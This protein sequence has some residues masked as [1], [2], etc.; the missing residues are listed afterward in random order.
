MWMSRKAVAAALRL[1]TRRSASLRP[2]FLLEIDPVAAYPGAAGSGHA[3]SITREIG[4]AS[5]VMAGLSKR[6]FGSVFK[7]A[8]AADEPVRDAATEFACIPEPNSGGRPAARADLKQTG[9]VPQ[10]DVPANRSPDGEAAERAHSESESVD[11]RD[12]GT[13]DTYLKESTRDDQFSTQLPIAQSEG[14]ELPASVEGL[15]RYTVVREHARG[16]LGMV[17]VAHDDTLDRQV[18]LKQIISKRADDP[19]SRDRFIREAKTTGQLEHPGI[20]PIYDL[21]I[22]ASGRPFYAMRFIE[23]RTFADAIQQF[24]GQGESF[25]TLE[26][27]QL[28]GRFVD[29]C[30]AVGYAHSHCV[31]HR[32]LKPE[33]VMLGQ[34]GE[35][36]VLDWGLAKRL[37]ADSGDDR[38]VKP[39][40]TD[41]V[42]DS[43]PGGSD[44]DFVTRLGISM[45]TP[46]Y[47]SPEQALGDVRQLGPPSDVYSLGATLYAL[48]TGRPPIVAD[49]L[50]SAMWRTSRGD[51]SPPRH[52]AAR[53]PKPLDAICT[54]AL[55]T[56]PGKRYQTA[57][58]LGEDVERWLA[59]SAVSAYRE[60]LLERLARF[61]RRHRTW[62][63]AGAAALLLTTI[64]ATLAAVL[65][66]RANLITNLNYGVDTSLQESSGLNELLG[67]SQTE[68]VRQ[69]LTLAP[70]SARANLDKIRDRFND[71]LG[72]A[73]Q[74]PRVDDATANQL[75]QQ[76]DRFER[77]AL[78]L[79]ASVATDDWAKVA[80]D[81]RD[82]VAAR[83]QRENIIVDFNADDLTAAGADHVATEAIIR[84]IGVQ[85]AKLELSP[86]GGVLQGQH[87]IEQWDRPV[88]LN[89]RQVVGN[90][91]VEATFADWERS[92][93]VGVAL[94]TDEGLAYEFLITTTDFDPE[95]VRPARLAMLRPLGGVPINDAVA[96]ILRGNEV[97]RRFAA[98]LAPG[99]M[100]IRA[101]RT[102]T[103]ELQI[104]INGRDTAS[105]VDSYPLPDELKGG[106]AL[107]WPTSSRLLG[108]KATVASPPRE[109][110]EWEAAD[111]D[112]LAGKYSTALETY[113]KYDTPEANYKAADCI[114]AIEGPEAAEPMF[115]AL[116][117]EFKAA[118]DG[119]GSPPNESADQIGVSEATTW[120]L[121]GATRLLTILA[122]LGETERLRLF[123]ADLAKN[124]QSE[125][126]KEILR[127]LPAYEREIALRYFSKMGNRFRIAFLPEGDIRDLELAAAMHDLLEA[128][129]KSRRAVRWRLA[130]A[131]RVVRHDGEA[132][133]ILRDLIADDD[134][135][136]RERCALISDLA[137]L[138]RND[139]RSG[140]AW[141]LLDDPPGRF[142]DEADALPLRVER[143]RL[144]LARNDV[145]GASD[146]LGQFLQFKTPGR[147]DHGIFA[148]AC[149]LRGM[150]LW[151]EGKREEAEKIWSEG[152]LRAW[153]EQGRPRP[154]NDQNLQGP[155]MFYLDYTA[156]TD[157]L[158]AVWSHE[159]TPSKIRQIVDV[160]LGGSGLGRA[161]KLVLLSK[162]PNQF[163]AEVL[164]LT[165]GTTA[166]R[167][168][169]RKML[170]C[171]M[172][173]GEG[174]LEVLAQLLNS[175]GVLTLYPHPDRKLSPELESFVQEQC[176]ELVAAFNEDH[177]S[178]ADMRSIL[179]LW[180]G[181]YDQDMWNSLLGNQAFK[182]PL[183]RG[184]AFLFGRV[185]ALRD[186]QQRAGE[187]YTYVLDNSPEEWLKELV[188]TEL[189]VKGS[190]VAE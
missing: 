26:F 18:A 41:T 124:V 96:V 116:W 161:V 28:L 62:M 53:V 159:L 38:V 143:A 5:R 17:S 11:E 177:L 61:G 125:R 2:S 173:L 144:L 172:R 21:H 64:A 90:V 25:D 136:P 129:A 66:G 73:L 166:G 71:R 164:Q 110:S 43:P 37:Q 190:D 152:T 59:G 121:R 49:S 54:R 175:A 178:E 23:G 122:S 88:I 76:I 189:Q 107:R 169:A 103:N 40:S 42:V 162:A 68:M 115:R 77:T 145:D 6:I 180:S 132:E 98:P 142:D 7:Q 120:Q 93:L 55:A 147:F 112:Y 47:M 182:P 67:D 56:S 135:D 3:S 16:G 101:A 102:R 131:H 13:V 146:E 39:Q 187:F 119:D 117:E 85:D 29:V 94:R 106:I 58:E 100:T 99:P 80:E 48:L 176:R 4:P 171:E 114:A 87:P 50:E 137:W 165:W 141:D 148:E 46:G 86:V 130:D 157:P 12:K 84:A 113:R 92:G 174:S 9:I 60:N 10:H 127:Q 156:R 27:R 24:H 63:M 52:A 69:L 140:E 183:K 45:G 109:P 8:S 118:H 81:W 95:F 65:I 57:K 163:I 91:V 111:A 70:Q 134:A 179:T 22:D 184:L 154:R 51:F 1:V 167:E 89:A 20:V 33:N 155:D 153:L 32:D 104:T 168:L 97:L 138:L 14:A 35:T 139:D 78:S 150:L 185:Y 126:F 128:D 123:A 186:E 151:N 158:L 160:H 19:E 30:N 170:W 83:R 74:Q 79:S 133:A 108:L 75:L 105:V 72:A 31:V 82:R 34:F 188:E 15:E 44:G 181:S 149:A 36:I